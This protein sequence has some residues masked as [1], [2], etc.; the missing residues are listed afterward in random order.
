MT[1]DY[2]LFNDVALDFC[3][4]WVTS[5]NNANACPADGQYSF[6]LPYQLP[7]GS[8]LTSWFATGWQGKAN[9]VVHTTQSNSSAVLANC[10][11]YF[12]TY[13]SAQSSASKWN[14][15]PTAFQVFVVLA[16]IVAIMVSF[17]FYRA[18]CRRK[19]KSL[20]DKSNG[21]FHSNLQEGLTEAQRS[22]ASATV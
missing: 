4:S 16:A 8:Q 15:R 10:D 18:C 7:S 21:E 11:L 17:M 1:L 22:T 3:G 2:Q 6:S 13:T 19:R 9:L 14:Q 12:Q 5:Q 20:E